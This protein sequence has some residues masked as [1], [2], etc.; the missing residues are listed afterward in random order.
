MALR[1]QPG[2]INTNRTLLTQVGTIALSIS[3]VALPKRPIMPSSQP[4]E[5]V[6]SLLGLDLQPMGNYA[7]SQHELHMGWAW[8]LNMM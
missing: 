2:R 6:A 4:M 1:P 8:L 7:H 5:N 3:R